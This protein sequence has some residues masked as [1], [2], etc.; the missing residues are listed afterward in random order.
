MAL[1]RPEIAIER[2]EEPLHRAEAVRRLR[3]GWT[4]TLIMNRKL[5]FT[6]ADSPVYWRTHRI[7]ELCDYLTGNVLEP[8]YA[9]DGLKWDGRSM[10]FFFFDNTCDPLEPT[11]TI[12]F[13]V[14]PLFAGRIG[15][16][17]SAILREL[18]K[19]KI[20]TGPFQ[21]ERHPALQTIQ[22]IRIPV[23]E[24]PTALVA[25]PEVNMSQMR[26]CLVLR[27]LL[28]YQKINGRYEFAPD[29]LL[30]R[31]STVTEDKIA[32]C[33]AS[34]VKAAEGVRRLPSPV[35]MKAIRRC[36]DEVK[37]FG[38]WAVNHNHRKLAAA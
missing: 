14:P 23:L 19:F 7:M 31:V 20:K 6:V 24:N 21:Y 15:E 4:E 2:K 11:G 38:L 9:K 37:Q 10:D 8:L 16:L 13:T 26:G 1:L 36:L 25:P 5:N 29:D 33:T 17:E 12:K 28:G 35:S 18:A 34:P 32:A 3:S 30:Q 27:D 22:V